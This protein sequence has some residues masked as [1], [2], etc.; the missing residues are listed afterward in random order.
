MPSGKLVPPLIFLPFIEN[1][2]KHAS[3]RK[4]NKGISIVLSVASKVV[5]LPTRNPFDVNGKSFEKKG[6]I[7]M[8]NAERRLQL[9]YGAH[10][11]IE[12]RQFDGYYEVNVQIPI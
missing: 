1:C 4:D 12:A 11:E 5:I 6:G 8:K 9:I 3:L 10:Y 2:F 7:G